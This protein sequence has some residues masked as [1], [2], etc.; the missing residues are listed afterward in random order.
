MED[1]RIISAIIAGAVSLFI[2]IVSS[3]IT[4]RVADKKH[5]R[6]YKLE[7]KVEELVLKFLNHP[8]WRFR[9]FKTVKHHIAGFEDNELR[10]IL[11]RVGA[12]R[13]EDS[14]GT[15]LWGLFERV[16]PELEAEV[17]T[18]GN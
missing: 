4:L 13:F 16:K 5:N 1:P 18:S 14:E 15:E 3:I 6:E 7:Y 9:T 2:A 10:Q 12:L 11:V 17:N 8:D